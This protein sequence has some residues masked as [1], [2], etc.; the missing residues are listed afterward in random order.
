MTKRHTG[1]KGE[2]QP[3]GIHR[4]CEGKAFVP[5]KC[6]KL[7]RTFDPEKGDSIVKAENQYHRKGG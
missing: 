3:E 4:R 7:P 1:P 5:S 6:G 2:L